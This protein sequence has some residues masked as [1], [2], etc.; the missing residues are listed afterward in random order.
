[1]WRP[2][3]HDTP[4]NPIE[5]SFKIPGCSVSIFL[6]SE[7]LT[8]KFSKKEEILVPPVCNQ[9]IT[10]GDTRILFNHWLRV[11]SAKI[12]YGC[13]STRIPVVCFFFGFFCFFN[14]FCFFKF[15]VFFLVFL[16]FFCS[17]EFL[18]FFF[19]FF[20][21]LAGIL[22][23]PVWFL[24]HE[25]PVCFSSSISS[26]NRSISTISFMVKVELETEEASGSA[27]INRWRWKI[28]SFYRK[29]NI[30]Q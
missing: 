27:T 1:M 17:F 16:N 15:F 19:V 24:S 6:R 5:G 2:R 20:F 18:Y 26:K 9:P 14:F 4:T 7:I 29:K 25:S 22:V 11:A 28:W 12:R 21:L 13:V 10:T 3:F 8:Q 30:I 23:K